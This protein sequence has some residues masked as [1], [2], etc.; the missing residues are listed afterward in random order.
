[1]FLVFFFLFKDVF[2]EEEGD[3]QLAETSI[4]TTVFTNLLGDLREFPTEIG[5]QVSY[6]FPNFSDIFSG[7]YNFEDMMPYFYGVAGLAIPICGGFILFILFFL[8]GQFVA[9]CSELRPQKS[10]KVTL[11]NSLYHL[12]LCLCF[13]VA[14]CLF[15]FAASNITKALNEIVAVV[16]NFYNTVNELY[17]TIDETVNRSILFADNKVDNATIVFNKFV[18]YIGGEFTNAANSADTVYNS[19]SEAETQSNSEL[20]SAAEKFDQDMETFYNQCPIPIESKM[21]DVITT[22]SEQITSLKEKSQGIVKAVEPLNQVKTDIEDVK[23]QITDEVTKELDKFQL[24]T[25][26]NAMNSLWDIINSFNNYADDAQKFVDTLNKYSNLIIYLIISYLVIVCAIFTSIYF[27]TCKAARCLAASYCTFALFVVLLIGPLT[28]IFSVLFFVIYDNCDTLE[29]QISSFVEIYTDDM[30]IRGLLLCPS[31]Y[32]SHS[33]Y[34]LAN[35]KQFIDYH[36]IFN[37][38]NDTVQGLVSSIE[39]DQSIYD[40]LSLTASLTENDFNTPIQTLNINGLKQTIQTTYKECDSYS[41]ENLNTLLSDLDAIE[42][43]FKPIGDS[44]N[45]AG[46]SLQSAI[47][48]SNNFPNE[49]QKT[50]DLTQ[51]IVTDCINGSYQIVDAGVMDLHC[52]RL[53]TVYVPARNGLCDTLVDAMTLWLLCG[54]ILAIII[55]FYTFAICQ[56]RKEMLPPKVKEESSYSGDYS[57]DE[58]SNPRNTKSKSARTSRAS[59]RIQKSKR[60]DNNN[61]NSNNGNKSSRKENTINDNTNNNGAKSSRKDNNSINN[62]SSSQKSSRKDGNNT[63][64]SSRKS[65]RKVSDDPAL[66]SSTKTSQQKNKKKSD[67]DEEEDVQIMSEEEDIS[68]KISQENL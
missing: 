8:I 36:Q 52:N 54:M 1:M 9:F 13:I 42:A 50:T 27:C 10:K 39:P 47:T 14:I 29:N 45:K 4:I 60:K 53:C 37:D 58:L 35:L 49:I 57:I 44:L 31:D 20:K 55:F 24:E 59:S 6:D 41:E 7:S 64:N 26:P 66:G 33:I 21:A 17:D 22:I 25:I 43:A 34:E 51:T 56:R 11:K 68:D 16:P 5:L 32:R 67:D 30:D 61:N 3:C 15:F 46:S 19:I 48:I 12:F 38:M 28:T 2:S 62:I 63:N 18:D 65:S 23:V 40:D